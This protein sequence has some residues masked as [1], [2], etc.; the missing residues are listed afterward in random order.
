MPPNNSL[1]RTARAP[2]MVMPLAFDSQCSHTEREN[3]L[4]WFV[5]GAR[6]SKR[7]AHA[8]SHFAA[9]ELER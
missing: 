9:G 1:H 8:S 3:Q 5:Q 6:F 2:R 7:P 4:K